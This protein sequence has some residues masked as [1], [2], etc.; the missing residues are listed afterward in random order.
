MSGHG[1]DFC[2]GRPLAHARVS[3]LER[4]GFL[5]HRQQDAALGRLAAGMGPF[6]S[7]RA[8]GDAM[9]T[10]L[11]R[12]GASGYPRNRA[13]GHRPKGRDGL[14]H[15]YLLTGAPTSADWIRRHPTVRN[16]EWGRLEDEFPH[17]AQ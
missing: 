16:A 2:R 1:A 13:T 8:A 12:Y 4:T 14:L 17:A 5:R 3:G 9:A 15:D 6:P 10:A 11:G 7:C